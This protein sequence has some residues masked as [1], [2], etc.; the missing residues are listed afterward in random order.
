MKSFQATAI[1]WMK[2]ILEHEY[3]VPHREIEWFS[4]LDEDIEFEK[5]KGLTLTRTARY[6][7]GARR[8]WSKAGSTRCCTPT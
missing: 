5:P 2:G 7:V 1:L 6:D 3:G 4:D 8:S